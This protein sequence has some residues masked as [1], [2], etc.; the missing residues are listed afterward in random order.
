LAEGALQYA[1][2][3][4]GPT[5]S[6]GLSH[7]TTFVFPGGASGPEEFDRRLRVTLSASIP[8]R[9]QWSTLTPILAASWERT[10]IHRPEEGKSPSTHGPVFMHATAGLSLTNV[11]SSPLAVATERG[12]RLYGALRRY[13]VGGI[14]YWKG[15]LSAR[16]HLPVAGHWVASPALAG[17]ATSGGQGPR[18]T[19]AELEGGTPPVASFS[20]PLGGSGLDLLDGLPLRGYAFSL[21]SR[22][23][24][25]GSLDTRLPLA[26][27]FNSWDTQPLFLEHLSL[28]AFGDLG[29]LPVPRLSLPSVG[30]GLK[31]TGTALV[32]MPATL[33]LAV[34]HGLKPDFGG[35]TQLILSL[36]ASGSIGL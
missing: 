22:H 1:Y 32:R 25:W 21:T 13:D 4:M 3:G 5:L 2:R 16:A 18:Q 28:F 15:A 8:F 35:E 33:T 30:G 19:R 23:V 26:W 11:E 7:E 31:L 29:Y 36:Q 9:L 14:P 6:L 10:N 27:I 34:H 24:A 17:I 20:S 12:Y